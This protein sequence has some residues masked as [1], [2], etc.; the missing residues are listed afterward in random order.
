M[1]RAIIKI[2]KT[3]AVYDGKEWSH[4]GGFE[5]SGLINLLNALNHNFGQQG[6]QPDP[7][8]AVAQDAAKYFKGRLISIDPLVLNDSPGVVY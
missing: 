4:A 8:Q 2:G 6:Y 1:R 5:D 7:L 3:E